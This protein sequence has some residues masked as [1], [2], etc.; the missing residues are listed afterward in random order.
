MSKK[1]RTFTADFKAKVGLEAL[2]R[3]FTWS[4]VVILE[5]VI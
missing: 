1:R 3:K 2:K 5:K 4:H